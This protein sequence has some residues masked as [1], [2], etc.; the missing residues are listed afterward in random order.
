[1][2]VAGGILGIIGGIIGFFVAMIALFAGGVSKAVSNVATDPTYS[3]GLTDKE[4]AD[5][6]QG[7]QS[8]NDFSNV[9]AGFGFI[10]LVLCVLGIVGGVF[11]FI[12]PP[13]G[14]IMMLIAGVGGLFFAFIFWIPSAFFLVLGAVLAFFGSFQKQNQPQTVGATLGYSAPGGYPPQGYPQQGYYPQPGYPQPQQ[15]YPQPQVYPQPTGFPAAPQYGQTGPQGYPPQ[16]AGQ[17][18]Y[19]PQTGPQQQYYPQNIT[20]PQGQQQIPPR[21]DTRL[22]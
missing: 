6:N 7:I 2:R 5:L 10:L 22:N 13:L 19:Q 3:A 17:S 18:G 9:A 12:K 4:K 20:A 8:I 16:S 15:G 14:A 21:D 1:M 11:G